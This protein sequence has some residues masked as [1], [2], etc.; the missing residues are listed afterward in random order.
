MVHKHAHTMGARAQREREREREIEREFGLMI[1]Y[2][3]LSKY[4]T[5]HR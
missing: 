2:T 5:L 4:Q 3:F 1:V